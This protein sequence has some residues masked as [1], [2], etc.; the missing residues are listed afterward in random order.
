MSNV[1]LYTVLLRQLTCKYSGM[2]LKRDWTSIGHQ[3]Y[4]PDTGPDNS[5]VFGNAYLGMRNI[6]AGNQIMNV[7][8]NA[9][10]DTI[11][12]TYEHSHISSIKSNP[13][14][15]I[16]V[17]NIDVDNKWCGP[18]PDVRRHYGTHAGTKWDFYLLLMTSL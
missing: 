16:K 3:V 8:V 11:A 1:L 18:L 4:I 5:W 14:H 10:N 12:V 17:V 2:T 7:A 13:R 9:D 15:T 6:R